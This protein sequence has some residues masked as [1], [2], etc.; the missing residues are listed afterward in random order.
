MRSCKE[1]E[2]QYNSLYDYS[3]IAGLDAIIIS[4]GTLCIYLDKDDREAFA[5]KYRSVPLVILEEYDED[6]PDSFIIS[7]NY[8][9]MYNIVD[10]LISFHGYKK[11]LYL[12]GPKN[13]TDSNDI[14]HKAAVFFSD[15]DHL[16]QI[17]DEL[18]IDDESEPGKLLALIKE[19]CREF[20]EGCDKPYYVEFSTGSFVFTCTENYSMGELTEKADECLYEAKKLRRENIIKQ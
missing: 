17:N 5:S 6:S 7:D 10:H 1:R 4:Y 11:I 18:I 8:G 15:L 2:C 9:S 20:N 12:S 16:K 19:K 13:N 3:L 14:G